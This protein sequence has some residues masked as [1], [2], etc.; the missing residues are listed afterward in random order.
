MSRGVAEAATGSA[1]IADTIDE[2][3]RLAGDTTEA[4]TSTRA[5][6]DGL[7]AVSV[8]MREL[9]GQFRY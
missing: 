9:V 4:S 5:A 6:A 7:S 1:S 3:A 2:V 8:R